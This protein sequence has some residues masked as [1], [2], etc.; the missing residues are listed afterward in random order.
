KE[1][2][3]NI[4]YYIFMNKN[5]IF[6]YRN[7]HFMAK[8]RYMAVEE[9]DMRIIKIL[10]NECNKKV[11]SDDG[12]KEVVSDKSK[13]DGDKEMIGNDKNKSNNN[14]N[15]P[16]ITDNKHT[17]TP[18]NIPNNKSNTTDNKNAI[19]H[20]KDINILCIRHL[21]LKDYDKD[22]IHV[23]DYDRYLIDC[24]RSSATRLKDSNIDIDS[25]YNTNIT[26]DIEK[27]KKYYEEL[28]LKKFRMHEESI[29]S[30]IYID[31]DKNK[32][33]TLIRLLNIFKKN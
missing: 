16:N 22:I 17:N 4:L 13:S 1:I 33:K 30:T 20:K 29:T 18:S 2:S 24:N 31:N 23:S 14:G 3:Y 27:D 8:I 25:I 15:K 5:I 21:F 12:D 19:E 26:Y 11:I 32:R 6:E 28:Y 10:I 7:T 9:K